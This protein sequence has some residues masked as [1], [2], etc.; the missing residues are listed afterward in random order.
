MKE[1]RDREGRKD[2]QGRNETFAFLPWFLIQKVLFQVLLMLAT[3][4]QDIFL[5]RSVERERESVCARERG[6]DM[7][8]R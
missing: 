1:K 3:F 5:L 8:E 7:K 4:I 6:R 2:R